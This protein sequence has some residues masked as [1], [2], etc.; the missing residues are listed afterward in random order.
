MVRVEGKN[1]KIS[2]KWEMQDQYVMIKEP[3]SVYLGHVVPFPG[4]GISLAVEI[5]R[6]C[7]AKGWDKDALVFGCDGTNP[8]VGSLQGCLAYLEKLL[9]HAV[10]WEIC[11]LHGNELPLRALFGFYDGKTSGPASFKGEQNYR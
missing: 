11:L 8:N 4:H 2:Y 5:F 6:F 3:Q 1:G 7:K 10:H 9:G